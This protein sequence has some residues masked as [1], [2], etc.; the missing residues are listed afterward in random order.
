M[1]FSTLPLFHF[2]TATHHSLTLSLSNF[3]TPAPYP[4]HF[5]SRGVN[6]GRSFIREAPME[7]KDRIIVALDVSTLEAA[8]PLIDALAPHVGL[9]KVGLELL[10]AVGAPAAVAAVRERGGR[11]M[12]DGK[13]CD[14]PNT[15]AG[16]TKAAVA[17]GADLL[18]VHASAGAESIR[19]AVREAGAAKVVGVTVLTSIGESECF[20][21]FGDSP[22]G[23]VIDFAGTLA[24]CGAPAVVCSPREAS[25][26]RH[27]PLLRITP[28]IRPAWAETGDQKR[29]LSP[30]D[31][32]RGGADMLVIGRPITKP[33]A[34]VG[35][36]ADA[37]RRI[38]DEIA[39]AL[40]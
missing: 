32:V 34:A 1:H 20:E 23:K 38:A 22:E 19:A 18:T 3:L 28:G 6:C 2:A 4:S 35:T 36:P 26:L 15:V 7:P 40:A 8:R 16:A 14:I 30:G 13:F 31:A 24:K 33:P 10:T 17:L 27:L 12:F 9:F 29:V 37:A 25:L 5:P 21:I 11:V 39:E